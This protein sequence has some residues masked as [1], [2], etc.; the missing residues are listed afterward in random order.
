MRSSIL[1]REFSVAVVLAVA[2]TACSSEGSDAGDQSQVGKPATISHIHGLGVDRSGT[3]FVATHYGLIK[4]GPTAGWVYASADTNDH[5]GFSLHPGDGTMYRSGHSP[6]KPS[7]GVQSST[8]GVRWTHLSDV[9]DPPV[10]FHAMAV[11]FADSTRLWG[12]DSGGRGTF[13]SADAGKTWTRVGARGIERQVY[14]LAGPP[15]PNVVYAGTESGLYR[16]DDGGDSWQATKTGGGGWVLAIATDPKD[17]KNLLVFTQRG[18]KATTDGG[19]TWTDAGGGL[20]ADARISSL[21]IS[22]SDARTA[23]AADS[24]KIYKTTDGGQTW[25]ALPTR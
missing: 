7:L 20:P 8:D 14:V 19:A 17:A 1:F 2:L 10:D 4:A 16:S 15:E 9:G 13:A 6:Q 11:S 5:M 23:F 22:P 3:P 21:A 25:T 12:W 24:S 18:M